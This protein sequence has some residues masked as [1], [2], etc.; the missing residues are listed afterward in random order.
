MYE[1]D[2][3]VGKD[4]RLNKPMMTMMTMMMM[5]MAVVLW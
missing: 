1:T 2:S 3:R 4:H 5:T